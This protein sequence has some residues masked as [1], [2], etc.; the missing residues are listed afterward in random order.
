MTFS[1]LQW[2]KSLHGMNMNPN[3]FRVLVTVYNYTN[4]DGR[5]AYP[6][7]EA[8]ARDCCISVSTVKRTLKELTEAGWLVK[9]TPGGRSGDGAHWAT[10]YELGNRWAGETKSHRVT[11]D[12]SM[13]HTGAVMGSYDYA[14]T[15]QIDDVNGSDPWDQW[16]TGDPPSDHVTTDHEITDH[17]SS[18]HECIS[19]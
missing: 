1:K 18:D 13:G 10:K 2:L 4:G 12:P 11:R 5:D 3:A 15:D 7:R 8:L 16:A 9:V 17:Y 6:G 19:A 14:S